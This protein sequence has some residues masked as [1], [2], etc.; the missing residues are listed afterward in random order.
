MA[1]FRYRS[2]VIELPPI[3]LPGVEKDLEDLE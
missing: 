3:L 2:E 1:N